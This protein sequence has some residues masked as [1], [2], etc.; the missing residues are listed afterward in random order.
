MYLKAD[1]FL[2]PAFWLSCAYY[3][4]L[5]LLIEESPMEKITFLEE[6]LNMASYLPSNISS[7]SREKFK[8]IQMFCLDILGTTYSV[9]GMY[10]FENSVHNEKSLNDVLGHFQKAL[11]CYRKLQDL[12]EDKIYI[13]K[14]SD[15]GTLKYFALTCQLAG[16]LKR[17]I[18]LLKHAMKFLDEA[19]K[20]FGILNHD[21]QSWISILRQLCPTVINEIKICLMQTVD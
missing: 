20:S 5:A 12:N 14:E 9:L 7:Q 17:D 6:S 21:H 19:I 16:Y 3:Y 11:H 4:K 1:M 10:Y 18:T 13:S 15:I 2:N 8:T